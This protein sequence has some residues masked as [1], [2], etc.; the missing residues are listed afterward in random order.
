MR[1]SSREQRKIHCVRSPPSLDQL[2]TSLVRSL[3]NSWWDLVS[4][5]KLHQLRYRTKLSRI[6]VSQERRREHRRV[7]ALIT[8]IMCVPVLGTIL[9]VVSTS[10]PVLSDLVPTTDKVGGYVVLSWRELL[11]PGRHALN[12][13]AARLDGAAVRAL[14]YMVK[15]DKP[16]RAG[17]L[18]QDFF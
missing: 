4:S 1:R 13:A 15:C 5:R 7:L 18:V 16:V 17:D 9:V 8:A 12:S 2:P 14:G 3:E 10:K 11:Q 6:Q